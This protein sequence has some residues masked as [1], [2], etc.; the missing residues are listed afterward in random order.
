MWIRRELQSTLQSVARTFPVTVLTGPRQVGKTSLAARAFPDH[1]YVTLDLATTAEMAESLPEEFLRRHPPPVV[2][3]EVQYA[4]GLFR[5]LKTAVDARAGDDGGKGLFVLTGS[6]SFPHMEGVAESLA[7]RA[8]V[9]PL[10]GLSGAEWSASLVGAPDWTRFL[11]AGSFPALWAEL[12]GAPERNRWYQG[13]VATYLERDVRNLLNVGSLR[14]FERF[15][16]AAATR[17]GQLLNMSEM[18]RDVG[19]STSTARQW[20]SVL[21][22]SGQIVLLEPYHRSLGK[23]LAKSPKLYFTDT[24]LAA[25][26]MGL[27]DPAAV[28]TCPMAGAL[29]ENHVVGQWL[30]WRHWHQPA[31]S[32]WFWRDQS[33]REVDL[34]IETGGRLIAIECKLTACP[35]RGDLRGLLALRRFY[36]EEAIGASY[37]ACAAPSPFH[38]AEGVEARCGWT[39]WE[40]PA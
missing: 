23:R 26:L 35:D 40:L 18:G 2:I 7:G 30:R 37:V 29:F 22:A 4:P 25:F 5:H 36:G 32:L 38:I 31:A 10:L 6:Q 17:C 19:I 12:A 21:Q 20:T 39:T 34:L 16:R 8:A 15:L 1:G 33:G 27:G 11:W 9:L 3:D 13:Y 28:H 24:G 14:D